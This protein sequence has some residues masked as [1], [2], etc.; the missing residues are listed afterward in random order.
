[1]TKPT[2]TDF[3]GEPR[4]RKAPTMSRS[5]GQLAA[6]YAPGAFFTFEGGL[7]ACM[8][9]PDYD[10]ATASASISQ[11]VRN[12]IVMRMEEAIKAWFA[13]AFHC[14]DNKPN[15]PPVLAAQC[16]TDELLNGTLTAVRSIDPNRFVF[17]S[18]DKMGYTPAPLTFVC[19]H[20]G[21]YRY[22]C[23][24]DDF[25]KRAAT[26][27]KLKCSQHAGDC[28]WRQLDVIFVHWSGN[29]EPV[30]PGRY[31]W[32]STD[33][34]VVE[35]FDRCP[36]CHETEF[37]L[38]TRH[39][40]T[41]IGGWYFVCKSCGHADTNGWK[42]N[43][44]ATLEI[45]RAD[46]ERFPAV[47]RMEAVSYRA[48]AAYYAQA[49]QFIIFDDKQESL[50]AYLDPD[51]SAQLKSF[52]A[53]RFGFGKGRPTMEEIEVILA[54]TEKG[55]ASLKKWKQKQAMLATVKDEPLVEMLKDDL[56]EIETGWFEGD[57][58]LIKQTTLLPPAIGDAVD[59]RKTDYD[60]RY[61]PFRLVVEH[62][63]LKR[64]H[65]DAPKAPT[66][67]SP[68][69][70]FDR[71]DRDLAPADPAVQAAQQIATR[72]DLDRL[73]IATMG[74]IRNFKLCRFTYGYTRVGANPTTERHNTFMP[75][76]L[77]LFPRV[78]TDQG[79]KKTPIYV[80]T[81]ENEAFYARLSDE[82]VYAWLSQLGLADGFTWTKGSDVPLGAKVLESA[83]PMQR[84]LMNVQPNQPPYAYYYTYTLLHTYSH[85]MMRAIAELSGLDAGSLGEYLFPADLAFVIYRSG[86]TL[87]LGNLSSLWRNYNRHFLA[88]LTEPTSLGCNSGSLCSVRGGAC[89]DCILIPETSCIASN[90]LLSR[91]V[92]RGGPR[93]REDVGTSRIP[94]YLEVVQSAL[95]A[96]AAAP[97]D[98]AVAA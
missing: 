95:A 33:K 62:E 7:G 30:R 53:E 67:R 48:A 49:D 96:P 28:H 59:A 81:Q 37:R 41:A 72:G 66:G 86:T 45:V 40:E 56:K 29:W 38:E 46:F 91:S 98:A 68:F 71:L 16:V 61:D 63:A 75:V 88:H 43:D 47:A 65:L 58:P 69:V 82:H 34:T 89:P 25:H 94:G 36:Q 26:A 60:A 39:S 54:Q 44:P 84:F 5:R 32:N 19:N 55:A 3:D 77:N 4:E 64:N 51:Q 73:G 10:T 31:N 85:L 42:K 23:S 1:M 35:P 17:A 6:A 93:P 13:S 90:H 20:C 57:P 22:F 76:R 74:L 52:L 83:R 27:L 2:I 70:P 24:V 12:Q 97:A 9:Q 18:P 15:L 14:R 21:T 87:D 92:L 50:L 11:N 79:V 78:K 8:A 80:V